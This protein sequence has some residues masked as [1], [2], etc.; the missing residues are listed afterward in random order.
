MG[1][2]RDRPTARPSGRSGPRRLATRVATRRGRGGTAEELLTG[3]WTTVRRWRNGGRSLA[4]K[5]NDMGVTGR[6]TGEANGVG[7]FCRGGGG[8][9]FIGPRE[10]HR[11]GE[12][13]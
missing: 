12:G 7:V 3:A 5:G 13:G 10:G 4:Q 8:G 1:S 9:P 6:R 2:H 11:G